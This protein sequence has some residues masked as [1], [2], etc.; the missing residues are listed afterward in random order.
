MRT[1]RHKATIC[2]LIFA[3][4]ATIDLSAARRERGPV[5]GTI[6]VANRGA[7]TVRAIDADTLEPVWTIPMA[8]NSQPGDL[9][10]AKHKVYVAE[11]LGTPP[12]IAIIDA[13]TGGVLSRIV[14]P[15]PSRP[16][17]VHASP[18]GNFVAVGLYGTDTVA[19]V[20]ART[21]SLIGMWDSNPASADGRIHAAVFS[22]DERTLYLAS[23]TTGQVIA[24]DT[25]TGTVWWR[26]AVPAAHEIAVTNDQKLLVVSRRSA[27]RLAVVHLDPNPGATP[28]GFEDVLSL[29]RPDTLRFS[30]NEAL[31]TV[32]LRGVP[33]PATLAVINTRTGAVDL[34]T[35]GPPGETTNIGGHQWTSSD[36]RY[37][38]ASYEGGS[39]PGVAIIDHTA[40]N[41]VIGTISYPGRPH[42]VEH[43]RP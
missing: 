6:W 8:T 18:G 40:G 17:H 39:N 26:L 27:D 13:S 7:N 36:G 43:T 24:M 5:N 28:G 33:G 2:L 42:G 21:D 15:A 16:H 37:T 25:L 12:A 35:I 23:D 29:P 34:V 31:L 4:A 3:S 1:D 38:L 19:V 9:A 14:L 32:G 41:R 20:D 11:E 10:V 22:N 30:A